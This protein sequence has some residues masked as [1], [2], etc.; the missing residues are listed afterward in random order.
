MVWELLGEYWR[1]V[2]V[3]GTGVAVLVLRRRLPR[4]V[5]AAWGLLVVAV[6]L[7]W[8]VGMSWPGTLVLFCGFVII[9]SAFWLRTEER[10]ALS[11]NGSASVSE[12]S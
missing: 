1:I 8:L 11:A 3:G 2:V 12:S 5:L 7:A 4:W 9:A 6:A 10:R